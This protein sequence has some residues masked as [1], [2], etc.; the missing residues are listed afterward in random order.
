M[1]L[2]GKISLFFSLFCFL[3]TLGLKLA[4]S[5]WMP[6]MTFGFGFGAF[7][8]V[9]A[10]AINLKF[11]FSVLQSESLHYVLKSFVSVALVVF[12]AL[13]LNYIFYKK[14][15]PIDLTANQIH[16]LAPLTKA[17]VG[18]LPNEMTIHYFHTGDGR[19]KGFEVQV[20]SFVQ[21][22]LE[23]S[24]K[25]KFQSHS[26]FKRPDLVNRFKLGDE[27]SALFIEYGDRV[28][29]VSDLKEAAVTDSILKLTKDPKKIYFINAYDERSLGDSS[30]FGL[31]EIRVQLERL[32]YKVEPLESLK[33]IPKDAAVIVL[34][35]TRQ[36]VPTDDIN[37]LNSYL[38]SGGA[39]LIAVDPG[40]EH[41]L[42]NFLKSY[43]VE[44]KNSFVFAAQ[45]RPGQSKLLAP[46]HRGRSQHEISGF[47]AE[48][49]NPYLYV[50]TSLEMG[51][52]PAEDVQLT[53]ILEH[54]PDSVGRADL[55]ETSEVV[56]RG[57]QIAG[58]IVEGQND[59][60]FR[61]VVMADSDFMTNNFYKMAGNFDLIMGIFNYLSKDEDL[62]KMKSPVAQ[63]TYLL[64]TQ[65]QLNLYFLFFVIPFALFFFIVGLFFRLRRMF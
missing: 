31:S 19:T 57:T 37:R 55:I 53:S 36:P 3:V 27:E 17:L 5:G 48:G 64:L 52:E 15:K 51:K 61:M 34:A 21:P 65:T 16:S 1:N 59:H 22:F 56:T 33:V 47:I 28:Q 50:S 30:S 60:Y 62:L 4:T 49:K 9:F 32:H 2:L 44:I 23:I 6:F 43:G 18:A 38:Q 12:I 45:A 8:L 39:L 41:N 54:I 11:F 40:E 7:F 35:G 10:V 13:T 42:D 58:L 25:L 20:R 26:I 24:D 63:T 14:S 46:T 29:R